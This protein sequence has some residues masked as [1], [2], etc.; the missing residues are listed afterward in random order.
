MYYYG[1][2]NKVYAMKWKVCKTNAGWTRFV[3]GHSFLGLE[4]N[5]IVRVF[6][7]SHCLVCESVSCSILD[8]EQYSTYSYEWQPQYKCVQQCECLRSF[9]SAATDLVTLSDWI[10]LDCVVLCWVY[11]FF[12]IFKA[13]THT[14][15]ANALC[16]VSILWVTYWSIVE[17]S[18][19]YLNSSLHFISFVSNSRRTI[20]VPACVPYSSKSRWRARRSR[21][22][23]HFPERATEPIGLS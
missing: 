4:H 2:P 18:V 15:N 13:H 8:S 7:G 1:S 3:S 9:T 11:F 21:F 22:P 16:V 10:G 12:S 19:K 6:Q 5:R 20:E 14:Q 17:H 23:T